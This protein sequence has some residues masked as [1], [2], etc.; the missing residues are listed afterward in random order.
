MKYNTALTAFFEQNRQ[1]LFAYL[2]RL[3]GDTHEAEDVF[4]D[5][6]I[7]YA[8]TYPDQQ[9]PALL[10]TV[11]KNIFLD[12]RRRHRFSEM[13]EG[14][15]PIDE[16]TPE[17]IVIYRQAQNRLKAA[18]N[19]IPQEERDLLAMAGAKGLKYDEI[20]KAAGISVANV[21]VRIHRA[22]QRLRSLLE[23]SDG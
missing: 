17:S 19:S 7:R 10:F 5:T 6:F 14:F 3:S 8:Q 9:N 13:P 11:A 20:A 22:R 23:V 12:G 1:K 21:K 16:Q 18:M 4:Q 2:V 15:E